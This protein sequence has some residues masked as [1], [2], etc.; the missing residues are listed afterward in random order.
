AATPA[1]WVAMRNL[2]RAEQQP[3][4]TQVV[5]DR[6]RDLLDRLASQPIE[7]IDVDAAFIERRNW[8]NARVELLAQDEV[9]FTTARSDVDDAR[10]FFLADFGP[11]DDAV[12][13]TA[14]G[15]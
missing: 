11:R 10:A 9:F 14:C 5:G 8:C 1:V 4:L 3:L 12:L 2:L 13:D 15:R 6:P 7:T